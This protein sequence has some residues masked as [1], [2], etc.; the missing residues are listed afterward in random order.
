ME[1]KEFYEYLGNIIKIQ[2]EK[3]LNKGKEYAQ[4]IDM[5]CNF[6]KAAKINDTT[7]E[8][9]LWGYATKHLCSIIDIV[10]NPDNVSEEKLL[11]KVTDMQCYL[12]L[13]A[14]LVK[15]RNNL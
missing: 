14:C 4:S 12:S 1:Q 13:L 8:Q 5:L 2:E 7:P 9:A 3:L 6:K 11:E 10:E 15:E